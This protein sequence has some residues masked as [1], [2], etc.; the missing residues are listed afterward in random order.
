MG[1]FRPRKAW[2]LRSLDLIIAG[3]VVS[4]TGR[5]H[6]RHCT[7]KPIFRK[8]L[9]VGHIKKDCRGWAASGYEEATGRQRVSKHTLRTPLAAR[10]CLNSQQK[11]EPHPGRDFLSGARVSAGSYLSIQRTPAKCLLKPLALLSDHPT[12][13]HEIPHALA[14]DVS[15]N[16]RGRRDGT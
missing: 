9:N 12:R 11:I 5:G 8:C 16:V 3:I 6:G 1:Q 7:R 14:F 13:G 2:L 10:V 15:S 4:S